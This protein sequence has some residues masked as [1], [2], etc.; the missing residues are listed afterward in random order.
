MSG[1][2]Q[3]KTLPES[4]IGGS[5]AETW[6]LYVLSRYPQWDN[7]WVEKVVEKYYWQRNSFIKSYFDEKYHAQ[8]N[9]VMLP[10]VAMDNVKNYEVIIRK[11]RQIK[12]SRANRKQYLVVVAYYISKEIAE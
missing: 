12:Y 4:K 8:H 7:T 1:T 11:Y 3:A 2:A 5:G 6:K 10:V 9:Y